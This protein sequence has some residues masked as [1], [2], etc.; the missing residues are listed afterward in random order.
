MKNNITIACGERRGRD[1]RDTDL[2]ISIVVLPFMVLPDETFAHQT[3][4]LNRGEITGAV[5]YIIDFCCC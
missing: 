3:H 5:Y 4:R 2:E 1:N